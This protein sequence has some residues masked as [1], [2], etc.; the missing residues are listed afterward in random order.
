MPGYQCDRSDVT[1]RGLANWY[2]QVLGSIF[3][4]SNKPFEVELVV[5]EV[6]E[7]PAAD[8][9]Y[10]ITFDGSVAE[11]HGWAARPT[12]SPGCSKTST[13][14]GSAWSARLGRPS[15]GCPGRATGIPPSSTP[16]SW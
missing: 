9:I 5:A 10:R 1:A 11:E 12:R 7:T 8:Q 13:A 16:A 15:P 2:A 4:E 3:T 14:K 6:G